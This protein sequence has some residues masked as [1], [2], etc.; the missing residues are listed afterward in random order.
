[1]N[2]TACT[3]QTQQRM[4]MV[5]ITKEVEQRLSVQEGICFISCTTSC[6]AISVHEKSEVLCQDMLY[7]M[8]KAFPTRDAFYHEASGKSAAHMKASALGNTQSLIVHEGKLLIEQNQRIYLCA[9]DGPCTCVVWVK[10]IE[11]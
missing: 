1:M 9:F 10:T 4:Q 7:G 5:D 6:C 2:L 11:G 3:I 8:E